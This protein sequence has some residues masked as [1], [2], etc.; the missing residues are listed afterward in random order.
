MNPWKL[1]AP[2]LALAGC[3]S[4]A[5][6]ASDGGAA[7]SEA[8]HTAVDA[9][10]SDAAQDAHPESAAPACNATDARSTPLTMS[11]QPDDGEQPFVD[12]LTP[13]KASIRVMI[14]DLATSQILTLLEQKAMAGVKV[15][16]I[17]DQTQMEFD[18]AAYTALQAA[19]AQVQ[20][21]NPKFAFTHAKTIVVDEKV[22]V[23]SSGNFDDA[24]IMGNRDYT[25]FDTD[26]QDVA[27]LVK[28]FDSD[29]ANVTPDLSCTRL[30]V[31]PVNSRA[32]ILAV[33]NSAQKTLDIE[34]LEFGDSQVQAAVTAK[35]KAG[36]TVRLLLSD[37]G[38]YSGITTA[39]SQMTR[40]GVTPRDLVMP[41]LHLKWICADGTSAYVGSE[42]LSSNSLDNNREVGLV[43]SQ[44][45]IIA[46]MEK[47]FSA[48]W[49]SSTS[50]SGSGD[51]GP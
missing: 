13:A 46:T 14:Y 42:N 22:G 32:R 15:Q 24:D 9:G 8:G 21:S 28:I 25:M 4:S 6:G 38:F 2:L 33:I 31:S 10:P 51:A 41:N 48:D 12:A 27:D 29:W 16:A 30:V 11:V 49:A 40:A 34:S 39:V 23:I 43:T 50:Y 3:S 35:Q 17:L 7:A 5:D 36:V 47:T 1:I 18:Q 20:W 44:P 19:G 45:D 37:P 26:P